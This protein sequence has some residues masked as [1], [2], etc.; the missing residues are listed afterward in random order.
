M[1]S[2]SHKK[3]LLMKIGVSVLTLSLFLLWSFNLKNI[4]NLN[5]Q[6]A[7][8][9]DD[10]STWDVLRNDVSRTMAMARGQF[11][12]VANSQKE[13][14]ASQGQDFLLDVLA[15]ARQAAVST[16]SSLST[17][18]VPIIIAPPIINLPPPATST[19]NINCPDWINCMPTVVGPND[20]M[21][22]MCQVPP[23]CEGITQIAY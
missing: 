14:D 4:W 12:E 10:V 19:K 15:T 11:N 22:A 2:D 6:I 3:V 9:S 13:E 7:R 20:N 5:N 8:N 23:G 17:G 21:P 1:F 18:T 16:S